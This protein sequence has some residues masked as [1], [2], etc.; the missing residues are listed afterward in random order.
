MT[1][2]TLT[3]R[4]TVHN[5]PRAPIMGI[6]TEPFSVAHFDNLEKK[7]ANA[8]VPFSRIL[9][10]SL[11]PKDIQAERA[12]I[13]VIKQGVSHLHGLCSGREIL[14]DL[15]LGYLAFS[16]CV[17]DDILE[18]FQSKQFDTH[19][20]MR[21]RDKL[22]VRRSQQSMSLIPGFSQVAT[23]GIG[24][25]HNMDTI[26]HLTT[27]KRNI[28]EILQMPSFVGNSAEVN[29]YKDDQCG[30]GFHGDV[31][32]LNVC[33]ARFGAPKKLSMQ[34]FHAFAPVGERFEVILEHGD[35]YFF[36]HK[37]TGTDWK[38]SSQYTLR[39]SAGSA[40]RYAPTNESLLAERT[41]QASDRAS[42]KRVKIV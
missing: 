11:L 37:A 20:R 4:D 18:D 8:N 7:L 41:I 22:C 15:K 31:E 2:Y 23:D 6:Q 10:N 19:C 12:E 9:L 34:W 38:K 30:V 14:E 3:I 29:H 36:S 16:D 28:A 42:K 5:Y 27:L 17:A 24:N 40:K 13:F 1:T 25:V 21:G 39:H 32:S 33:A 35:F 26:P